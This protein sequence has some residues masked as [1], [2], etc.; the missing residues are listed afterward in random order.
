MDGKLGPPDALIARV[1]ERQY[2]VISVAQ[3]SRAG[4]SEDAI[5]GRVLSGR[6]HRLHR[7]VYAVGHAALP[8]EGRCVAAVLALAGG[9]PPAGRQT[10]RELI[11]DRWGTAVSHRSAAAVWALLDVTESPIDVSVIRGGRAKRQ[12]IRAHRSR[13]LRPAHVTLSRDIQ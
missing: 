1:A 3:L 10:G 8:F 6:L 5:R 12:G 4:V 9:P 11:L 2:G 13:S 7:G